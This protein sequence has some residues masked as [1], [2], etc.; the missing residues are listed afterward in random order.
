MSGF[1]GSARDCQKEESWLFKNYRKRID[2]NFA[3]HTSL[4]LQCVMFQIKVHKR[5]PLLCMQLSVIELLQ[6]GETRGKKSNKYVC[7]QG[8][9][10]WWPKEQ[11]ISLEVTLW[12]Y[13]VREIKVSF[14]LF[15]NFFDLPSWCV[16]RCSASGKTHNH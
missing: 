7:A 10:I 16:W 13:S 1:G 11:F 9:I 15:Q 8:K 12:R 4:C 6:G 5:L 2:I 14:L 3:C